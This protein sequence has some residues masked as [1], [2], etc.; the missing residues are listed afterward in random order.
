MSLDELKNYEL[1]KDYALKELGL[2]LFGVADL[3]KFKNELSAEVA[4][5]SGGMGAAISLAFK[6]SSAVLNSITDHPTRLYM[7]H[8]QIVNRYL[9]Y[10]ALRIGKFIERLG[11][12]YIP[13]PASLFLGKTDKH[14]SHLSHRVAAYYAG[15]GWIGRNNLLVNPRYG[16]QIRLVT[17]LTDLPLKFDNPIPFGCGECR[18]CIEVCP[19]GALSENGYDFEK[20]FK[21]LD[22]FVGKY[23]VGQHIC[24]V[25]VKVCTGKG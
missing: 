12:N 16:A 5:V 15:L 23:N 19:A 21:L 14:S 13:I 8:Y 7:H 18:K 4:E 11:G 1:L 25:C 6:L 20:C 2:D 3:S 22:Y 9:D 24:G 10:S 17:V